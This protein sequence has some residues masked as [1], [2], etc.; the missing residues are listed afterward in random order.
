[1]RSRSAVSGK[2]PTLAPSRSAACAGSLVPGM[3]QVQS[4]CASRYLRKNRAQLSAPIS[5]AQSGSCRSAPR[6]SGTLAITA[7]LRSRHSA[8]VASPRQSRRSNREFAG[9][10]CVRRRGSVRARRRPR[11]CSASVRHTEQCPRTAS[12]AA[13]RAACCI[14][15]IRRTPNRRSESFI[16]AMPAVRPLVQT[17]VMMNARPLPPVAAS[18]SPARASARPYMGDE[19]T[20]LPPAANNR[21]TTS[22][23]R[24][25]SPTLPETSNPL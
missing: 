13:F 20:M 8:G 6:P 21:R 19:S 11:P 25:R 7:T 12:G 4:G 14:K 3:T 2:R 10:R 18:A 15:A 1:M 22:E 16:C 9:N 23:S 24:W 17:L 5:R